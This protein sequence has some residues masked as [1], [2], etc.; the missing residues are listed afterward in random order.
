LIR[1]NF[2]LRNLYK[3]S[4]HSKDAMRTL[5]IKRL[6]FYGMEGGVRCQRAQCGKGRRENTSR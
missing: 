1:E 6:K 4:T 5:R 3:N 2:I